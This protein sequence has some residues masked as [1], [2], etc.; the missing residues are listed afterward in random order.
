MSSTGRR[1]ASW[2]WWTWRGGNHSRTCHTGWPRLSR[3]WEEVCS[4]L[5]CL[6]GRCFSWSGRGEVWRAPCVS[7]Q[8][9]SV[10]P[11]RGERERT[12]TW[13]SLLSFQGGGRGG[14]QALGGAPRLHIFRDLGKQWTGGDGYVPGQRRQ[15]P[16]GCRHYSL[17]AGFLLPDSQAGRVRAGNQNSQ[18]GEETGKM[19]TSTTAAIF[20]N[21]RW[22]KKMSPN[23]CQWLWS[24]WVPWLEW[25]T[26]GQ[27]VP[28]PHLLHLLHPNLQQS[29]RASSGDS[30]PPGTP[31]ASWDSP[32]AAARRRST[33]PTGRVDTISF[34]SWFYIG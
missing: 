24:R 18:T 23:I 15:T 12:R 3:R 22:N 26:G 27:R 33:G 6:H 10:T 32:G 30:G 5:L 25:G 31:G 29:R 21:S 20:Q 16:L 11:V 1:T 14:G 2:W 17:I 9:T 13:L 7:W 19:I 34:L 4:G 8:P 28:G